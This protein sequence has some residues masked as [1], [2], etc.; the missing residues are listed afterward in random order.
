MKNQVKK[1]EFCENYQKIFSEKIKPFNINIVSVSKTDKLCSLFHI[2]LC[3][4]INSR[5]QKELITNDF[6]RMERVF[7]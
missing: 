2:L 6:M 7:N 1:S 3:A 5:K 4:T